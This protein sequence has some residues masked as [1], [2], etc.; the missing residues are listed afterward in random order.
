MISYEEIF[1]GKVA[2]HYADQSLNDFGRA[3]AVKIEE[4]LEKLNPDTSLI[5]LLAD[6]ARFGWELGR[7]RDIL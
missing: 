7:K 5:A 3:I 2:L 6:A 4:E 1:Q